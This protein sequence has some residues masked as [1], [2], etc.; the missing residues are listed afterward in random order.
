MAMASRE[1]ACSCG[2][3]RLEADGDPIR[4]SVCHC[5]ACQRRTGSAF[6]AQARFPVERVRVTGNHTEYVRLADDDGEERRFHFCPAC[7]GTV[8]YTTGNAPDLIAVP[9]GAFADPAFPAPTVSVYESRRHPWVALSDTIE[10]DDVWAALHP[11][12]EAGRYEEAA[13]RGRELVEAHPEYSH[14]AY[15]VAC[16][17]SLAGRTSDAIEHLRLAVEHSEE[18]R[19]QAAEDSDLDAIRGE[20][21]LRELV[22]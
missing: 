1:A 13:D 4:I 9:L 14:L 2:Q 3:L 10:R 17:E 20:P 5:L 21:A 15:N 19:R 11:L 12:Y 18:L 16:C 22:G 6:G 7:G 8:F